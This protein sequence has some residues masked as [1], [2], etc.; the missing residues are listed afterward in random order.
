MFGIFNAVIRT[1]S[2][3]D[4]WNTHPRPVERSSRKDAE[5]SHWK[6]RPGESW[7]DKR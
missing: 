2:R 3:T 4:R 5:L 1:A 6:L 7:T